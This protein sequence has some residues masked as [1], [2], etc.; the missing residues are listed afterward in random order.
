MTTK[1]A[2]QSNSHFSAWLNFSFFLPPS[3]LN[4]LLSSSLG[5]TG[6]DV[7]AAE[8]A[9]TKHQ[10]RSYFSSLFLLLALPPLPSLSSSHVCCLLPPL[11]PPP[12]SSSLQSIL[13]PGL[14][15][16]R[17][18]A[19]CPQINRPYSPLRQAAEATSSLYLAVQY[20]CV[21]GGRQKG[22]RA[23]SLPV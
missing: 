23:A 9:I 12:P 21:C 15:K 19:F 14:G 5:K 2:S 13:Q 4:P 22:P 11:T 8:R 1:V 6:S 10:C 3:P 17:S 20:V 7:T 18:G 16:M